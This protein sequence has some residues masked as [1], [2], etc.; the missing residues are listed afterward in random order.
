MQIY[1]FAL[2]VQL[3]SSSATVNWTASTRTLKFA[4]Y[5]GTD[6]PI[7]FGIRVTREETSDYGYYEYVTVVAY[8]NGSAYTEYV[9]DSYVD[10]P[11]LEDNLTIVGH[12]QRSVGSV[13]WSS[14][15][16]LVIMDPAQLLT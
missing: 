14:H 15:T 13:T 3:W 4:A 5:D 11:Q 2:T 6:Y 9:Y 10:K 8:R 12:N 7:T 16:G 1:G